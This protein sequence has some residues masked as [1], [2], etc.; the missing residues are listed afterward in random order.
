[1]QILPDNSR[2]W[3]YGSRARGDNHDESDWDLIILLDKAV[4]DRDDFNE[5]AFP[6]TMLGVDYQQIVNPVIFGASQ[7]KNI[8]HTPFY[9]NV[10]SDKII[11]R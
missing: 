10:E 7:W 1:M 11:L 3:L 4:A 6:F 5:Y 2:L 9:T 8:A